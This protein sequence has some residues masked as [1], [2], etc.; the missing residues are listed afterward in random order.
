M[1]KNIL[2]IEPAYNNPYPPM[3]LMKISTWHK[4]QGDDVQFVKDNEHLEIVDNY[5][6]NGR[7]YQKFNEHYDIIY[8]TSLFT[9]N[10]FYVIRSIV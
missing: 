7:C 8:I 2:L 6:R 5:M 10:A 3:G 1:N 9:Y 4:R